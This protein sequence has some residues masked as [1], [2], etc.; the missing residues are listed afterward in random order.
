MQLRTESSLRPSRI[1]L[2]FSGGLDST[3]ALALLRSDGYEVTLIEVEHPGRPEGEK[4]AA[5]A[6][7]AHFELPRLVVQVDFGCLR[8]LSARPSA[9]L[10]TSIAEHAARTLS[11]RDVVMATIREDWEI[12]GEPEAGQYYLSTV[13]RLLRMHSS[14]PVQLHMPYRMHSKSELSRA[15]YAIGAP[16]DLSWSCTAALNR[17]C[18]CCVPCLQAIAAIRAAKQ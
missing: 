8:D 9:L 13:Q 2:L 17:P 5:A 14:E 15:A 6:I 16:L 3:A 1:G 18:G 4:A 7:A 11:L 12:C 10:L